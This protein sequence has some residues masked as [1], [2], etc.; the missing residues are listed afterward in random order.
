MELPLANTGGRWAPLYGRVVRPAGG[1]GLSIRYNIGGYRTQLALRACVMKTVGRSTRNWGWGEGTTK[2]K[3]SHLKKK[4]SDQNTRYSIP[5]FRPVNSV[6]WPLSNV[7]EGVIQGRVFA[8]VFTSKYCTS[9]AQGPAGHTR[10]GP[11]LFLL[12]DF[13]DCMIFV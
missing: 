1:I 8:I 4:G 10:A 11:Y 3:T 13:R 12:Q 9:F 6:P 2:Q 5:A 7:M